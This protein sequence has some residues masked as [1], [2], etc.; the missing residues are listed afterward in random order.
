MLLLYKFDPRWDVFFW[1]PATVNHSSWCP[2][3]FN[4]AIWVSP[5]LS[6]NPRS[7]LWAPFDTEG[8][9]GFCFPSWLLRCHWSLFPCI[10]LHWKSWFPSSSLLRFI[11]KLK[12]QPGSLWFPC[13]TY[14]SLFF[15][16]HRIQ[17]RK[18]S[19]NQSRFSF[20]EQQKNWFFMCEWGRALL[21]N[22]TPDPSHCLSCNTTRPS[23]DPKSLPNHFDLDLH[24]C[25]QTLDFS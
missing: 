8:G 3:P 5:L 10:P 25:F 22:A 16:S 11:Y 1:L 23:L 20:I 2:L 24:C 6:S 19:Y 14:F 18:P 7:R 21:F 15:C 13:V 4:H 9:C 12:S 17:Y